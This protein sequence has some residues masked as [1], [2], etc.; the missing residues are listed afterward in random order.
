MAKGNSLSMQISFE[1][2]KN[3][4]PAKLDQVLRVMLLKIQRNNHLEENSNKKKHLSHE[5]SDLKMCALLLLL[6]ISRS[7]LRKKE[8]TGQPTSLHS[9]TQ[10]REW[11]FQN[12]LYVF[13]GTTPELDFCPLHVHMCMCN[14]PQINVCTHTYMYHHTR[15]E[16]KRFFNSYTNLFSF[17]IKKTLKLVA[18]NKGD[19]VSSQFRKPNVQDQ[20]ALSV[21]PRMKSCL[22]SPQYSREMGRD[23]AEHRMRKKCLV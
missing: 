15:K 7:N 2:M 16:S 21:F 18:Y 8:L 5:F 6:S 12:R 1:I 19:L 4:L 3:Q 11:L 10:A 9:M 17:T 13:W 22:I 20:E 23:P 14:C